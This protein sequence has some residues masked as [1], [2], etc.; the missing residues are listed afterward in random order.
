MRDI[1]ADHYARDEILGTILRALADEGKDL[2]RLTPLDLAPIDEFHI[3]GRQAT[4]ELADLV[5]LAPG[6]RVLDVGCGLGGSVRYLAQER[7]CRAVGVDLTPQYIEVATALAGLVGLDRKVEFRQ[8]SALALPFPDHAFDAV[9]TEH[10]QMNIADKAAFYR[11]LARVLAP[12]GRLVFHDVFQGAGGPVHFPVPWADDRSISFLVDAESARAEIER[13]GLAVSHW[14]DLTQ[15]SLD[16]FIAMTEK[17]KRVGRAPLGLHLLMGDNAGSKS[18][19]NIANLRE[20]RI[21]VVQ[22][23]CIK[24]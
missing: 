2:A 16:W 7:G 13:A 21:V 11:E 4:I 15:R 1:V 9:W 3:R 20:G 17:A 10:V 24:S 18:A 12:G 8:G 19:N 5:A 23:T 6:Q 14:E 22:A